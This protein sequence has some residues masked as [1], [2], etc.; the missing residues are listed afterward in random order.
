M[1][2]HPI[3]K[4]PS[5]IRIAAPPG[6]GKST[7]LPHLVEVARGRAVVADIDEILEDGALLGVPIAD[8][9]A[10]H[11]WPAYN[12]LWAQIAGFVTRADFPVVLLDQV[13]GVDEPADPALL[14]WEVEDSVRADRL[15]SRGEH[16]ALIADAATD[17]AVLRSLL[18]AERLLRTP[19]T[20]S[21]ARC[22][23]ILW[24]QVVRIGGLR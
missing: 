20:A 19:E 4:L 17:A 15:R 3:A 5:L 13:P 24:E 21:P 9:A 8:P 22:A 16:D 12:R 14:G 1:T 11:I 10:A 2:S 7:V 23:E 6:T 18:P